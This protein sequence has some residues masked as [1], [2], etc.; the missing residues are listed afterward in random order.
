MLTSVE[1]SKDRDYK[2]NSDNEPIQFYLDAL[3]NSTEF[4]LLLGYFSSAAI[5]LLSIG[6]ATFISKG[7]KMKMV[8]NHLLS[9]K[10]KSAIE[11]GLSTEINNRVFDISDVAMLSKVLDEYDQHFFECL[12]YLIA[13]KRIE[14]KI[15]RPKGSNG[16]SHYKSGVFSDG[17]NHVG[18]KASCN[19]TL[20]GLSENLEELDAYLSWENGRSNKLINKQIRTIDDYFN[21][22]DTDVEYLTSNDI[23]VAIRDKF[24]GKSIDE[25][26]VQEEDLLR[27]KG[28][29]INNPKVKKTVNRLC[30]EIDIQIRS[31]KFPNGG[32]A[33][34]YQVEAYNN[35][36]T[37]N[38]KGIFAMATGTGKTITSLN[39]LL[40]E[41]L[42]NKD[43]IYHCLILV[44]TITLV[45]QWTEE[46]KKFNFRDIICVS[47]KNDWEPELATTLSTNRRV[48][49]S[50]III[51]TYASFIKD[52]FSKYIKDLPSDTVFIADEAH[53]IGSPSVLNKLNIISLEKRIGLSATPKR[54]Y[55]IEGSLEMEKFFS[56]KEPYTYSF[57]M[58]RA[59]DEGIL[60]KYYYFPHLVNLTTEEFIE[61]VEI[62]KK[63]SKFFNSQS[64]T[65]EGNDILQMLLL[66]RKR[67]I[68]KA[69]NKL[70]ITKNILET[71]FNKE[72][73]LKYTFIYVPEGVTTEASEEDNDDESVRLIK[74]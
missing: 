36:V 73:N 30:D 42:K 64:N 48:P 32:K 7:G 31:P 6:F 62:T 55:D 68:H 21:E 14:I 60:C 66:K 18:Y 56:D 46:A 52:R 20:Y 70:A 65:F 41:T 9:Q 1:W 38:Y 11:N 10:D 57:S 3:A 58:E 69:T 15:I 47:S 22:V 5:N 2:T 4:H 16:I 12:A 53:N 13:E 29:L 34:E 25:L 50:F 23:E 37:N 71:R 51:S 39:C 28:K 27:K 59:I 24:G 8:I 43:S 72:G 45:N 40:Q 49:I 63:L 17:K 74:H 19:F 35:W 61:Y 26:I 67:I 54:I 44:P 33:R